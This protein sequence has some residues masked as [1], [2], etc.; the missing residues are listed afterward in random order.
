MEIK[1]VDGHCLTHPSTHVSS[2]RQSLGPSREPP[3]A[4]PQTE[5]REQGEGRA[6]NPHPKVASYFRSSGQLQEVAVH[7]IS[8]LRGFH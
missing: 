3:L 2:T 7:L 1:D 5:L 8:V 4:W 6:A